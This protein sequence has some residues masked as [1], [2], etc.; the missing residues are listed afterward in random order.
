M[1]KQHVFSLFAFLTWST[2]MQNGWFKVVTLL[3][4]LNVYSLIYTMFLAFEF[5]Q[6]TFHTT[7]II[8]L[9]NSLKVILKNNTLNWVRMKDS[10]NWS[11]YSSSALHSL[12]AT[13]RKL[14]NRKSICLK[15]SLYISVSLNIEIIK[16]EHYKMTTIC[17]S[18][19][20]ILFR[21]IR[22]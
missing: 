11:L 10:H 12:G 20:A 16:I 3:G 19:A 22:M 2:S 7:I 5:S 9:Y 1:N 4:Y 17:K 8:I 6:N 21:H 13:V 14:G 18:H 15:M